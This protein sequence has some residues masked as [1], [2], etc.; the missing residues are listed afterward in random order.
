MPLLVVTVI[1]P[2]APLVETFAVI[3]LV[4]TTVNE[5]AFT[6]PNFT[7]P[8]VLMLEKLL[9]FMVTVVPL[10]PNA[11]VNDVITGDWAFAQKYMHKETAVAIKYEIYLFMK[12]LNYKVYKC[13]NTSICASKSILKNKFMHQSSI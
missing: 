10:G 4:L 9:P 8:E 13:K 2:V 1:K 3:L 11:G 5:F 12:N 6:P 7:P